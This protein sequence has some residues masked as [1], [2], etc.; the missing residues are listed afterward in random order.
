[1]PKSGSGALKRACYK[2]EH[3]LIIQQTSFNSSPA[4]ALKRFCTIILKGV[5]R[6][7]NVNILRSNCRFIS[8]I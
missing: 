5:Y 7:K 3:D 2:G 1:M 4:K 6:H 8:I